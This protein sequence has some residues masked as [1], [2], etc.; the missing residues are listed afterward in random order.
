MH[1]TSLYEN[2][3]I[4]HTLAA[5]TLLNNVYYYCKGLQSNYLHCNDPVA[6]ALNLSSSQDITQ[7]SDHDFGWSPK[8]IKSL[9]QIDREV[10]ANG[11]TYSELEA[12]FLLPNGKE[13]Q[14]LSHKMPLRNAQS[15][16]IGIVGISIDVSQINKTNDNLFNISGPLS[17]QEKISKNIH[18]KLSKR[19]AECLHYLINGKTARETALLIHLSPR[20]VELHLNNLKEKFN[21]R[22]KSELIATIINFLN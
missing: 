22:K 8:R 16:I 1:A 14:L 12:P 7:F 2:N 10:I 21:C 4:I 15:D 11:Q 9:Q 18:F 6:N 17:L 19:E 3:P 20:T 13:I 5:N